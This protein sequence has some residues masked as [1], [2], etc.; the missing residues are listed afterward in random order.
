[1][2]VIAT[3]EVVDDSTSVGS[4]SGTG[5]S[6]SSG[7]STTTGPAE[8]LELRGPIDYCDECFNAQAYLRPC[9]GE[10][11]WVCLTG[12]DDSIWPCDGAY[13][14]VRGTY[15]PNPVT[16]IDAPCGP[17]LFEVSEVVEMRRCEPD[18]CG[19]GCTEG[20]T[21]QTLC[22]GEES[23]A[24]DQKCVPWAMPGLPYGSYRC[25]DVLDDAKPAGEACSVDAARPW[26]DDC[27]VASFCFG[28]V[29][30]GNCGEDVS[31]EACSEGVCTVG[32]RLAVCLPPC[33][34]LMPDCEADE[35]CMGSASF[36]CVPASQAPSV[37]PWGCPV[38]DSGDVCVAA[39]FLPGCEDE[40]CC[41]AVCETGS[42]DCDEGQV[43]MPWDP[44]TP[45]GVGACVVEGAG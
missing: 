4:S 13:A 17:W 18:D 24:D 40:A 35:I 39:E 44:E 38:C 23:C 41:T 10:D 6:E 9:E 22:W 34:P 16:G 15:V 33:D 14:H 28:G 3:T 1:M 29:C 11:D 42:P 36:V 31:D 37:V 25:A 12:N 30:R 20:Y 7:S 21:C 2:E 45:D 32:E 19:V 27:D 5:A 43:C 26:N 8:V